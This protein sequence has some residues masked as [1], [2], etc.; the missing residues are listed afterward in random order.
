[1]SCLWDAADGK[2]RGR[3]ELQAKGAS[4]LAFS[5]NGEYL[6]AGGDAGG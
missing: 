4:V 1:M 3:M 2:E 6:T 5:P